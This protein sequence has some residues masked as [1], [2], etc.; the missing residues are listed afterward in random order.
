MKISLL[1]LSIDRYE[2]TKNVLNHNISNH[3]FPGEIELLFC[4]NGSK[5]QRTIDF[6]DAKKPAYFRRNSVNEGCGKAFNQLFLR[7]TGDFIVLLGNDIELPTR[8]LN[9]FYNFHG[10]VRGQVGQP[11]IF[12]IDWGHGSVP[13]INNKNG[14]QAHWL[15]PTLNRIFGVW[16]FPRSIIETIGFFHEGFDV[17]GI[18][19]S[20]FNERVN[21]AGFLSC[22]LP[23]LKSRHLVNDVG[24][25]SDYRRMKDASAGKN[26]GIFM[27]RVK[28]F[29]ENTLSLIER[30]PPMR[31]PI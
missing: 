7:S 19:D 1:M 24:E 30:I 25:N 5:D 29:D 26:I 3:G 10:L 11:G 20:D 15:T 22:Y 18:E 14:C 9:L 12:G 16:F 27:D 13:P 4:D 28:K 21:R 6:L 17:Y 31:E 8:W 2:V 23:Y